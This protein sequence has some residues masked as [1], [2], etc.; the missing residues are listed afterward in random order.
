MCDVDRGA[1]DNAGV[2]GG[3]CDGA[4]IGDAAGE[5]RTRHLYGRLAAVR[6]DLAG[7]VDEDAAGQRAGVRDL[8]G[9]GAGV[10]GDAAGHGA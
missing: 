8:A 4:V 6:G 2:I 10:D 9:D 3:R 1:D 5:D 7:A